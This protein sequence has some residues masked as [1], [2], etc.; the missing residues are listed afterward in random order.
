MSESRRK[1]SEAEISANI[2]KI[3]LNETKKSHIVY[4]ANL[5]FEVIERYLKLLCKNN[6]ISLSNNKTFKTTEKGLKYINQFEGFQNY[7][8]TNSSI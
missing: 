8:K 1:R 7:L 3:A 4:Q 2:L 6:L 5:N